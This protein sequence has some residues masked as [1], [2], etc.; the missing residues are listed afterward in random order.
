VKIYLSKSY[1]R[2]NWLFFRLIL[3]HIGLCL[4]M[5]KWVEGILNSSFFDFLVNGS[6]T[7]FLTPLEGYEGLPPISN[8]ILF[9]S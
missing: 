6:A 5:V 3:I 2:G 1:H 9:S 7:Y 4:P 8:S